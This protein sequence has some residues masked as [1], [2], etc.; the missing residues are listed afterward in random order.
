MAPTLLLAASGGGLSALFFLSVLAG[1]GGALILAYMAPLPL[2]MLGLGPGLAAALVGGATATAMVGALSNVVAAGAFALANLMPALLVVRQ[3]LL[4]RP[5]ADGTLE[6][7]PPGLLVMALAGYGVALLAGAAAV[8]AG[9]PEGLEGAVRDALAGSVEALAAGL[10]GGGMADAEALAAFVDV[11]VPVFPALVVV[12]WLAMTVMN[13]A[14]AQGLLMR[15]GRNRR[16]PMRMDDLSLPAWA[17]IAL[18][19]A[20]LPAV[21]ADGVIGYVSVNAAL[22]LLVPFFM[23]GLAVVHAFAGRRG[24]RPLMLVLFYLFLLLFQWVV[25]L[26]VGLGLIE[27]W[28]GLRRRIAGAAPH[29]E[30]V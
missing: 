26:V 2:L 1:G 24:A 29:S 6:W 11:L 3:A 13:G 25:P 16:P 20:A 22:V 18:A 27:Q 30:D 23:A 28:A 7:Y 19:A 9:T 10:V 15:F 17:P 5:R 21:L 4:A 8:A 14:L 12:S